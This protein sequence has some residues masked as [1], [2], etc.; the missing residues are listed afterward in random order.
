MAKDFPYGTEEPIKIP[1]VADK[2]LKDYFDI[3]KTL[4]ILS[5]IAYGLCLGFV[6]DGKY[7]PG[8][9]DLDV[10]VVTASNILTPALLE[11]LI[12]HG[13]KRG[14]S[15]LPPM[16]NTHF[17]K[18]GILLDIFFRKPEK[19]YAKLSHVT[20]KGRDYAVPH[21]IEEYLTKCYGDWKVKSEE[22]TKYYG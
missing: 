11:A 16:N 5:C 15:F 12:E 2:I 19:F 8:D 4:K 10:V 7:I 3:V 14:Q 1:D 18:D 9:N 6:R 17:Y 22:P 21:P 13:F 20:Y